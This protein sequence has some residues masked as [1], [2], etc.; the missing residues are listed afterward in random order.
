MWFWAYVAAFG[1]VVGGIYWALTYEDAGTAEVPSAGEGQVVA[2]IEASS[3]VK[4]GSEAELWVD[5]DKLHFFDPATGQSL[6]AGAAEAV[7]T[8]AGRSAAGPADTPT[9]SS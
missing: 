9:A 2:R 7:A 8:A 3:Q 1:L 6:A 4:R 5:T